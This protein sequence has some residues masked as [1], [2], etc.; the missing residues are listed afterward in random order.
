MAFLK[1][2]KGEIEI[3]TDVQ[4]EGD[5]GKVIPVSFKTTWRK[6][7]VTETKHLTEEARKPGFDE[8]AAIRQH[9]V[10]WRDLKGADDSD[11]PFSDDVVSE[12]LEHRDYR[13]ALSKA[14][15]QV[16]FGVKAVEEKN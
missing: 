10:N 8:D 11:V 15:L 14:F 12:M 6:L 9:L 4:V 1:G 2:N 16:A 7:T 5:L 13:R 3:K